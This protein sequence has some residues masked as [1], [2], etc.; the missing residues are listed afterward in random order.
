MIILELNIGTH[1]PPRAT[2]VISLNNNISSRIE[3]Q[4]YFFSNLFLDAY[5]LSF[6]ADHVSYEYSGVDLSFLC[7]FPNKK[8][9]CQSP[10]SLKLRQGRAQPICSNVLCMLYF[11]NKTPASH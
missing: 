10:R 3:F 1:Q 5:E 8:S 4:V 7:Q 9:A 11:L 2:P 6:A